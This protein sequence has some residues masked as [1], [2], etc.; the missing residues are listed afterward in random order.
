MKQTILILTGLLVMHIATA[1]QKVQQYAIKSGYVEY[2]LSGNTTGI[3]KIW[4][5]Y[6]GEKSRIE[7][8]SE[9]ITKMFG[10]KN[11]DRTH[12]IEILVKDKYWT[13]NLTDQSGHKGT[14]PYYKESRMLVDNMT[15]KEQDEF[16]NQ[17]INSFGGERLRS[18]KHMGKTCDVIKV[19]GSKIWIHKGITLKAEAK[20][21]GIVSN[22]TAIKFQTNQSISAS[23]FIPPSGITYNNISQEQ[24]DIFG[25]MSDMA[26]MD[27]TDSY[28]NENVQMIP[29]KYPFDTFLKKIN[30][31]SY[32]GYKKVI[33]NSSGGIHNA[34]FMKGFGTTLG[35]AAISRK[36]GDMSKEGNFERFTHKG[37]KC[38]YG[39]GD[40]N[41]K[42]VSMLLIVEIP[43]YDTY[44]TIGSTPPQ[45]KYEMLEILNQ[46]EF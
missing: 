21:L 23:N 37:K 18:E 46:F 32:E 34:A 31:F 1:Q 35:I 41:G 42:A 38:M 17:V 16:A 28:D 43:R 13:A 40:E 33:A 39:T 19:M 2:T 20:L 36:N 10:M 15:K 44:I 25:A 12:T 26:A 11:V 14:L 24:Q 4:W 6:F 45:T 22:E 7:I 5:D 8:Q 29:V 9:T 30:A 27:N 3:K